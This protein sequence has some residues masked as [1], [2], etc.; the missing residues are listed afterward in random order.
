MASLWVA[1]PGRLDGE[2]TAVGSKNAA[3]PIL[4]GALLSS[5][6]VVVH[7]VPRLRDVKVMLAMMGPL[8]VAVEASTE[9]D[10]QYTVRLRAQADGPTEAADALVRQMRSSVFLLG[11][12]LARRGAVHITLPGGCDIGARPIDYHLGGLERL[13]ATVTQDGDRLTLSATRLRGGDVALPF[14]SV[15]ATENLMMAACLAEGSTVIRGAAREPEIVDL[16]RFLKRLGARLQGEGTST[17]HIRGVPSLSGGEYRVMP[18]RIETGTLLAAAVAAGG[19][20]RVSGGRADH[21]EAFLSFLARAGAKVRTDDRGVEVSMDRRPEA[22]DVVT[23]PYPGFATDL[24]PIAMAVLSRCRGTAAVH[25][26][27]FENRLR[28]AAEL[29]RLGPRI[30]VVG[31]TA[32]IDGVARTQGARMRATDLRG[33]AGLAVAALAAEGDSEILGAEH[34]DRGYQDFTL[35]LAELGGRVRRVE[36]VAELEQD[37]GAQAS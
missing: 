6:D 18:D 20:V 15:G 16:A 35:R 9:P 7:R 31:R 3:L 25:E 34:L 14:P 21:L 27:I 11:P 12:L 30:R 36:G 5:G 8:G 23:Q 4:A 22:A 28:H 32:V 24:Q 10:G 1:G 2:V 19:R 29:A 37:L 26:T 17:L 13:G 33:A